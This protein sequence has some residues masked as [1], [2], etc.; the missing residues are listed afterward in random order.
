MKKETYYDAQDLRAIEAGF[1]L[2]AN[3]SIY[4]ARQLE[5]IRA[6][7]YDVKRPALNAVALMPVDTSINPGAES[8]TYR[9]YDTVGIAKIIANYADDLPRADVVAKEFTSPVRGIGNSYGYSVQEIR[10]ASYTG[11]PLDSKKSG[12]TR[13]AHDETINKYAF[14]GDTVSGLPGF[15]SNANIPGYTIPADGTGSSKLF[16]TKTPDQIL[17]DMNGI[18]NSVYVTTKGVHRPNELWM[19]LAQYTYI[20]S[21]PRSSTSD[22]TILEYFL[23]NNPFIERVIPVLEVGSTANGGLNGANDTMIAME[24]NS[25]NWQLNLPMMFMQHAPEKRG[26]EFVVPCESRFAGVTVPY[27]MAFSKADSI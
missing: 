24:N 26:L 25:D 11:T 17:R 27:P 8:I 3:E 14:S 21:T 16:S 1:I 18:V 12:A 2:D 19:P 20:N 15:L 4:F 7:T 5:Q 10:A 22:T 6:K 13:R 9:Q 23:S